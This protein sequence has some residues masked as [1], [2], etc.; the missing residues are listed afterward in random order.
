MKTELLYEGQVFKNYKRMCE[1]L[2]LE[3]KHGANSKD[4]QFKELARYCSYEKCGHKITV[5]EVFVE[6]KD[7]IDNRGK[8]KGSRENR[9][10]KTSLSITNP[11]LAS[12]WSIEDNGYELPDSVTRRIFDKEYWWICPDCNKKIYSSPLKRFRYNLGVSDKHITCTYCNLSKGAKRVFDFLYRNG[13]DFKTE[14]IFEDLR[15]IRDGYLRF[16]FAV[17]EQGKLKHLIEYDGGFHDKNSFDEGKLNETF[18]HDKLKND[19]CKSNNIPLTR[20][21]HTNQNSTEVILSEVFNGDHSC[22]IIL[23]EMNILR[24]EKE[25]LLAQ[26][27]KV[28]EKLNECESLLLKNKG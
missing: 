27:K 1:E 18:S 15:G 9:I 3:I 20:I 14:Y 11:K 13:M 22:K 23:G 28:N 26:I 7:K 19:Y 8:S 25:N 12:Q 10:L 6:V 2:E 16:D 5:T 17:F 24:E 4:A 21:H